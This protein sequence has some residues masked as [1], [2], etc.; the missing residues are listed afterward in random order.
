MCQ[1]KGNP[2][3]K[4]L[5]IFMSNGY[6]LQVDDSFEEIMAFLDNKILGPDE[7][8]IITY[9]SGLRSACRKRDIIGIG[10]YIED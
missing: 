8:I 4:K 7:Y 5:E 1:I 9:K 10:E 6:V 3:V 2:E